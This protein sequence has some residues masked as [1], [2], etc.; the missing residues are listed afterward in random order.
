MSDRAAN[1]LAALMLE[2]NPA[3]TPRELRDP[4]RDSARS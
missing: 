3:L 4:D 1:S 2:S